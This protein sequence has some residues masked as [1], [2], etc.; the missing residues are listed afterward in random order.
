MDSHIDTMDISSGTRH[1]VYSE[2]ALLQ[3]PNRMHGNQHLIYNKRGAIYRLNIN[4]RAVEQINTGGILQTSTA[5]YSSSSQCPAAFS[6]SISICML[7]E[8]TSIYSFSVGISRY[9]LNFSPQCIEQLQVL[10][11]PAALRFNNYYPG[12]SFTHHP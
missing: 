4:T 12:F 5:V 7:S 1:I 10:F 8:S 6:R 9:S 11:C 3:A 2:N